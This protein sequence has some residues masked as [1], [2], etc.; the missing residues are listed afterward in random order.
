MNRSHDPKHYFQK[1][2][3]GKHPAYPLAR[4]AYFGPDGQFA[5]RVTVSIVLSE[6]DLARAVRK[7]WRSET[8]DVRQDPEINRAI[9]EY[10]QEQG[11]S[12][13]A[14]LDGV[15]HEPPEGD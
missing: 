9:L 15:H 1:K 8:V 11:V 12:K 13:V 5:S 14:I 3:P 6:G 10:I 4:I 7:T 2:G